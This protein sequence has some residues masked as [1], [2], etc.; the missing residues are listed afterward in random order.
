MPQACPACPVAARGSG[1]AVGLV[2][3]AF[4]IVGDRAG[5]HALAGKDQF[6][7]SRD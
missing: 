3:A 6:V 4:A 2:A 1:E 7:R 5:F